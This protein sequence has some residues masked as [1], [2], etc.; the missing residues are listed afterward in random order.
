[1]EVFSKKTRGTAATVVDASKRRLKLYGPAAKEALV[2]EA[3]RPV[4]KSVGGALVAQPS[5]WI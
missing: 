4:R 1:M 2:D 5:F 3:K